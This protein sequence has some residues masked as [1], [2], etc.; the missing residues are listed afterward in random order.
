M[1]KQ[2]V[3]ADYEMSNSVCFAIQSACLESPQV[4]I[5]MKLSLPDRAATFNCIS[6]AAFQTP[7]ESQFP[8]SM[9][10]EMKVITGNDVDRCRASPVVEEYP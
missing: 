1:Q 2:T 8:S 4:V 6:Q 7:G 3:P 10:H 5:R 9:S